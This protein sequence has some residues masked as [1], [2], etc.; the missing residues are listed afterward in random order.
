[1]TNNGVEQTLVRSANKEWSWAKGTGPINTVN[2]QSLL[3]TLSK[4]HGVRWVGSTTAQHGFDKPQVVIAF[5]T[6]T[7]DKAAHKVV[8]GAPAGNGM[9]FAKV[10]EREGTF[11]MNNPDFNA[12]R[13]QLVAEPVAS[14]VPSA[15]AS[16]SASPAASP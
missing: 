5:T 10:D 8:V 11:V 6:S 2:A 13:L 15:S 12:L 16:A 9:W 3:N 4:L 14:P 7:D 1:V